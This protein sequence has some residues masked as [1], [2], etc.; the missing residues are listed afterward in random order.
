MRKIVLIIS[1]FIMVLSITSCRTEHGV[2]TLPPW[3]KKYIP[4]FYE[5]THSWTYPSPEGNFTIT[6]YEEGS[7]EFYRNGH[8]VDN[9]VQYHTANT[10]HATCWTYNYE[11]HGGWDVV[12][13]KF[14][15]NERSQGFLMDLMGVSVDPSLDLE[16]V[17]RLSRKLVQRSTPNSN[18]WWDFD[19]RVLTSDEF[20]WSYTYPDGHIDYWEMH[21]IR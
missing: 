8:Y 14:R 2:S 7:I 1:V 4:G 3:Q 13:S 18:R 16:V 20:T 17:D 12:D 15:F 6:C 5:Y 21:R 19:I 11:C 9:A 10:P